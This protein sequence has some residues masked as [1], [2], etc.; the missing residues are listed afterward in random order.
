MPLILMLMLTHGH[1]PPFLMLTYSQPH[2]PCV[3]MLQLL[4]VT[5]TLCSDAHT[6]PWS[7]PPDSYWLTQ[8][9]F[10]YSAS[11]LSSGQTLKAWR[12]GLLVCSVYC[13]LV[14]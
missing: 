12:H 6:H 11:F 3:L 7:L 13:S 1:A 8:T 4:V 9:S 2:M 10:E 14:C 5:H